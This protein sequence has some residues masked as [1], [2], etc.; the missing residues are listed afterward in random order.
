MRHVVH[1]SY[2]FHAICFNDFLAAKNCKK[3]SHSLNGFIIFSMVCDG[4]LKRVVSE[5]RFW[6]PHCMNICVPVYT[7]SLCLWWPY[8]CAVYLYFN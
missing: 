5:I 3:L 7:T 4:T 2:L 8:T 1:A 6:G